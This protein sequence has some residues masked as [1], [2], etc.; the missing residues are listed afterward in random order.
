LV[1][2]TDQPW[3][4]TMDDGAQIKEITRR[5]SYWR[6]IS[7]AKRA[8]VDFASMICEDYFEATLPYHW[9]E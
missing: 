3:G 9:L 4:D 8:R 5:N 6:L 2:A 7:I 1:I